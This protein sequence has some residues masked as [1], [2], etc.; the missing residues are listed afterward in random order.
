MRS[1][2]VAIA[3]SNES[4][5]Q[6]RYDSYSLGFSRL[7]YAEIGAGSVATTF[8][9]AS[10]QLFTHSSS[11]GDQP[12]SSRSFHNS[13]SA[14]CSSAADG[15]RRKTRER[16]LGMD[17][18]NE[19]GFE[20]EWTTRKPGACGQQESG[21]YDG[22]DVMKAHLVWCVHGSSATVYTTDRKSVV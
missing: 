3:V 12:V 6:F 13:V 2:S 22:N 7:R 17:R 4:F 18:M 20:R 15:P 11:P 9:R 8:L 1:F 21:K 14:F 16:K 10:S 19:N 5:W